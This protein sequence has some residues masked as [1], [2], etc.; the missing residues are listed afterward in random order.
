MIIWM[1]DKMNGPAANK[2]LKLLEEPPAKTVFILITESTSD[3]LQT[4]LSRC[5]VID[6][7]GLSESV[8]AEALVSRETNARLGGIVT[9]WAT[10]GPQTTSLDW[11]MSFLC[12]ETPE[13]RSNHVRV[14]WSRPP[15]NSSRCGR[16]RRRR[17]QAAGDRISLSKPAAM[18]STLAKGVTTGDGKDTRVPKLRGLREGPP[19]GRFGKHRIEICRGGGRG[20][21]ARTRVGGLGTGREMANR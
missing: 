2:L 16:W 1:A 19:K 6:F 21:P 4:I 5:Q 15:T 10:I 14:E 13:R 12:C 18:E 17:D 8:I 20:S 3:M 9:A 7:I 11:G